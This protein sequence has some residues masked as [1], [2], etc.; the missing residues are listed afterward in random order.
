MIDDYWQYNNVILSISIITVG[1]GWQNLN[2]GSRYFR[3]HWV[4]CGRST[5]GEISNNVIH[6]GGSNSNHI[7]DFYIN[8]QVSN[9]LWTFFAYFTTNLSPGE[10]TLLQLDPAF[11]AEK[12][13]ITS[14]MCHPLMTSSYQFWPPRVD[15]Q[16]FPTTCGAFVQS[17]A[18]PSAIVGHAINWPHPM[19]S[20]S[21]Q[22]FVAHPLQAIQ[23]EFGA[24]PNPDLPA[25]VP[26]IIV[27]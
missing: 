13:G 4:P 6:V 27:I 23:V 10:P 11:P 2:T 21:A 15:P 16:L 7:P 12:T 25:I 19:R 8:S 26:T 17:G 20:L 5:A 24:T 22:E 14:A 3:F 18:V 9:F 1:S